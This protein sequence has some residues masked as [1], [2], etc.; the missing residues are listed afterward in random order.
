M[1][2]LETKKILMLL[3]ITIVSTGLKAQNATEIVKRADDKMRGEKSGFSE[4]SM[5]IVRPTWSRTITFKSW[6]KGTELSLVYIKSPAKDKGQTFLKLNREMWNWNPQISRMIKLP[7]SML[8]QGWMGS[9]FTVDDALNQRSIVV[10]Y[11]HSILAE[12]EIEGEMCYKILLD[13]KEDAPVV[14]GKIYMWISKKYD[15][16]LR[17]EYYDEDDYL[18]KTELGYNLKDFNGR[19]LPATF[20]IIPAD[21]EGH[22][23]V[24]TVSEMK[25]NIPIEDA[26]FSQQNMKRVR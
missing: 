10:D 22:K 17:T 7:T 23:T 12:E 18:V 1:K 25:F 5:E 6:S 11:T 8:S 9:D 3:V 24:V 16:N 19:Y 26:F 4:M 13:P 14:W 21:E 2:T 15:I 20:E